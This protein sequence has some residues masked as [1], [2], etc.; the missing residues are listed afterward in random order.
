MK[1]LLTKLLTSQLNTKKLL[2]YALFIFLALVVQNMLFTQLRI[3][4]VCPLVLPAAVVAAG[5]F[6]GPVAGAIISVLLGLFAD[7]AFVENT[8]LFTLLFP[9]LS[10][11]AGF[12]AQFFLNRRFFAYMG[13][14]AVGLLLTGLIQMLLTAARD[15]F[16]LGMLSAVLLQTLWAMPFA[17]L[18]YLAAAHWMQ[19]R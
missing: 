7:M 6:E 19:K 2:R 1:E 4:G 14:A 10:F 8:V 15:S 16:S 9:I 11:G 12:M 13:A 18:A 17:P 5:M 3:L